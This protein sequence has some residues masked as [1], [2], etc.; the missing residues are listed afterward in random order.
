MKA[1]YIVC[2]EQQPNKSK[3]KLI[4]INYVK[5]DRKMKKEEVAMIGF[6]IVAY[7]G[8]ARSKFLEAIKKVKAGSTKED[9]QGLIDEGNNSLNLAHA[10]QTKLLAMEAG[11]ED[12]ELGFIFVHGQDHLMTSIL[13]KDV[14]EFL[15][16]IYK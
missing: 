6:E 7:S 12:V 2:N 5:G 1:V 10:S 13:L 16:D 11:G 8:E 3:Q 9:V 4:K 14:L 15:M